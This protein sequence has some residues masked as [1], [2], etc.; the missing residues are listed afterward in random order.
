[1]SYTRTDSN[2]LLKTNFKTFRKKISSKT[3]FIRSEMKR[4]DPEITECQKTAIYVDLNR[5]NNKIE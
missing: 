2:K 1:M 5:H 4:T 3:K